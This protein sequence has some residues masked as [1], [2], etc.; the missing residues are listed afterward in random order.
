MTET[1]AGRGRVDPAVAADAARDFLRDYL[2]DA[3][4][5]GYV[6]GVS[7]GLD[8]AVGIRLAV[9]AVGA[10]QVRA[11]VLP[12]APSDPANMADAR[13]LCESLGVAWVEETIE[14]QVETVREG[15]LD[16][17]EQDT[18][19]VRAR[20]RMVRLYASA[21]ERGMLVLGPDNRSEHLLGYF[22][23]GGDGVVDVA[24]LRGLYKTEVVALARHLDLDERFVEKEPTAGLW[25]GQTDRAELG[26]PYGEI[27]PVLRCLVDD[28]LDVEATAAR[29][30]AGRETVARLAELH[31]ESAH[32]RRP[33]PT[34]GLR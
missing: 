9:E 16:L 22:T 14:S 25:E 4:A 2:A 1:N 29:V 12:G 7:G 24:P 5:N 3:G 33:A 26:A 20:A 6:V 27:D 28:G 15:A 8:S 21:N 10:E 13:D 32:K 23:K 19:N 11:L 17:D 30:E 31:A 18:G 34:P